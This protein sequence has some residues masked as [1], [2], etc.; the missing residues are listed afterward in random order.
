HG[1]AF[2]DHYTIEP[3]LGGA[4]MYKRLADSLHARGM[5][6]IQ[7]AVYNHVGLYHFFV[8]DLPGKSWLHQWPKYTQTN[9]RDQPLFDPH[10]SAIDKKIMSDG[11]FSREMP[12]LNQDNPDVAE[13]LI[14]HAIWCVETFGV[15]GFRI[16]TYIYCSLPFM[17]KCNSALIAEFPHITMFGETWVHGTANQAYFVRNTIDVP[18][19]SNLMGA[20][21]FQMLFSGIQ[22][23]IR[24]STGSWDGGE[25]ALYNTLSNDFLYQ[26]PTR[27]VVFLDNHDMTRFFSEV[28]ESVASQRMGI[29]WLLTERGIPEMYYGTEIC[30]AGID[31][32]DGYVRLDFPG[33][34][35][36]DT[37][38]G[39]T[40]EG[41]SPEQLA[42]QQLVRKLGGFRL[43]SSALRT[44]K[45][46]QY[47]P[48]GG[49]YVYFRYDE[50]QTVLCAM[51]NTTKPL[52]L[53]FSRFTER[54]AGFTRAVD[55]L[56][57]GSH[58]LDQPAEIPARTMWVLELQK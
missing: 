13:F 2:T 39:F 46:M 41:L 6:L 14:E 8:Q 23:A 50:R 51:N 58:A 17:N 34:W 37:K 33:G 9:Y 54:T 18:F 57:G 15:D 47:A 56:D 55:V 5:K 3:R 22:P 40:G 20:C 19:K 30:M 16:D 49:L 28:N 53:D 24:D 12:D 10:G 11:W 35:P 45:L 25:G 52:K 43:H 36:G 31:H 32:P 42:V 4:V 48:Q 21:D 38:S 26:D 29:E 1:Y 44:G 7:D 27:N